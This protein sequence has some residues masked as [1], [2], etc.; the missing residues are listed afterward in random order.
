MITIQ[1]IYDEHSFDGSIRI[2]V[3][4]LW[5]RGISKEKTQID[6]WFR[7]LAPSNELRKWY[8][9]DHEKWEE[10]RRFYQAELSSQESK[11][12]ELM[13]LIKDNKAVFLFA[14]KETEK[15]NATA[16]KLYLETI[17]DQ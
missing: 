11:V 8:Q 15:N 10:F 7:D 9:H 13:G 6:H 16:L 3:D 14:S 17:M 5:P 12:L 4:R 2:L 1:R